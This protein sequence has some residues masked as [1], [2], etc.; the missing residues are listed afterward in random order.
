AQFVTYVALGEAGRQTPDGQ[1][2]T[3]LKFTADDMTSTSVADATDAYDLPN[4]PD[5][6][7]YLAGGYAIHGTYWHD[8]FGTNQSH[9]CIN[10]TW[11]DG[12]YL[13]GLTQPDVAS[14]QLEA[15][16]SADNPATPVVIVN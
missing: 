9:G 4:V 2:S 11:T 14:G 13:F 12:A 5:T 6:Q 1:Y 7:Y 3:F 8:L 15:S 16:A 10:V